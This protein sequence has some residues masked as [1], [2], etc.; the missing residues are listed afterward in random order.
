MKNPTTRAMPTFKSYSALDSHPSRLTECLLSKAV[1]RNIKCIGVVLLIEQISGKTE[2]S[3]RWPGSVK[4]TRLLYTVKSGILVL[5]A[6][7]NWA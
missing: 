3:Y 1:G 6:L 5:G 2:S 7:V 4:L